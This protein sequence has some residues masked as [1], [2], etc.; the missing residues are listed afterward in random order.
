MIAAKYIRLG[1]MLQIQM[2]IYRYTLTNVSVG[3]VGY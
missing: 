2:C 3:A 1:M